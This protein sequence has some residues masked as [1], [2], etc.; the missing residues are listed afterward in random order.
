M[1][2]LLDLGG[3]RALCDDAHLSAGFSAWDHLYPDIYCVS[4]LQQMTCVCVHLSPRTA[5]ASLRSIFDRKPP[6]THCS[7]ILFP[8]MTPLRNSWRPTKAAVIAPTPTIMGVAIGEGSKYVKE[9]VQ[10]NVK[11]RELLVSAPTNSDLV[12]HFHLPKMNS[13]VFCYQNMR[14]SRR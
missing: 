1:A 9:H 13:S 5:T 4:I 7:A 14:P 11:L 2:N 12:L 6:F 3:L 10:R 8:P